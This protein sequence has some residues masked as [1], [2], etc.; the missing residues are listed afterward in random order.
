MSLS[1]KI[2]INCGR[3]Q[4]GR[5][6]L[7]PACRALKVFTS[8]ALRLFILC[9]ILT[10]AGCAGPPEKKQH[11]PNVLFIIVDDLRPELPCYGK[12][13]IHAPNIDRLAGHGVV[14]E[15]AFC[16]Y[17]VCG[18][19]RCSFLTGLRPTRERFVNN[20]AQVDID[21]PEIP[22]M[23]QLFKEQGYYTISNGKVY[24]DHGNVM[25]G[26]D[27]WSEIPWE[28]HPGFWVWLDPSS[29]Q[30]NYR[31]FKYR[32]ETTRDM[33]PAW[34]CLD[35][36]DNAYPTGVVT[37]KTIHDLQRLAEMDQPFYLAVGYR[38]PHLPL[39][40]PK[41]Y[42]DLY[43]RSD[44]TLPDNFNSARDL[45][46]ALQINNGELRN[47]GNIPD[48]GEIDLQDW[49]TLLHGYKACVSYTDAQIGRL[50]GEMDRLGLSGN[51]IVVLIGDHGY[52]LAEYKVWGKNN[53]LRL[54]LRAPLIISVPWLDERGH[55]GSLVEFVDIYPTLVDVCGLEMPDHLA[56]ISLSGQLG[57]GAGKPEKDAVYSRVG[58]AE[59]ILT[60]HYAYTEWR[61]QEGQVYGRMLFDHYK[62]PEESKNLAKNPGY[63]SVVDSLSA[64]LNEHLASRN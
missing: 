25:D 15:N 12:S 33:G 16:Q 9:I 40:A 22:P 3:D 42:W 11:R 28:P 23:P 38:K 31:G 17:P 44:I 39:N 47:Y 53:P 37:D 51:T 43:D 10:T 4:A 50:I 48:T 21:A 61:D 41:K 49:I 6:S 57:A 62:D 45:S 52:N 8:P 14:F 60:S 5:R 35:V 36:P 26:M 1:M 18:P 34:E 30:H 7:T 56:G 27:G 59:I 64:L 29:R 46:P 54:S 63:M 32:L 20:S 13:M 19:S 55:S 24:H 58:N 2:R